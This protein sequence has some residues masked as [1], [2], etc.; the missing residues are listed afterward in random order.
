MPTAEPVVVLKNTFAPWKGPGRSLKFEE[1]TAGLSPRRLLRDGLPPAG[2]LR[3]HTHRLGFLRRPF[4]T[5]LLVRLLGRGLHAWGD[6][7]GR[8]EPITW[9]HLARL[10]GDWW[11]D[12]WAAGPYLRAKLREIADLAAT[13]A[14]AANRAEGRPYYLRTDLV[15]GLTSGGSIAHITGVFNRLD[16]FT[17]SP[18]LFSSDA[19]RGIRA[20]L[21]TVTVLPGARFRDDPELAFLHFTDTFAAKVVRLTADRPP[22]FLYQRYSTNNYAGVRLRR[23]W[24]VPLVLEFNG[25]EVWANQHW[26][27]GLK[28]LPLSAAVEKLNLQA[29]DVIVVVSDALRDSLVAEGVDGGKVLVNPNGVEPDHFSPDL[30]GGPVRRRLGLGDR[31]V[32]GFIGTFEVWHGVEVLVEAFA[33]LLRRRPD[34]GDRCRLL[35]V[36]DGPGFGRVKELAASL[37][38]GERC[39]FTGRVVQE[40]APAHLAAC[41]V[42]VSPTL[43]NKDGSR[44]FGSPTKLFEYMAMGK[45][46]VAS[47]LDQLGQVLRHGATAWLTPPG[48]AAAVRQ[49]LE[50]LIDAPELRH[51]LGAAARAEV[52]AK[53]TWGEHVR[54]ILA[55]LQER[56][57]GVRGLRGL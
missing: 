56:C 45:A 16:H 55:K 13:V 29:A 36:G 27:G 35:L 50:A 53:Y 19:I 33:E 3:L 12:R 52:L 15:F 26:R 51:R 17:P 31:T 22:P 47:D 57:P 49:G 9:G 41:D 18:I 11:R 38:V 24:G 14:P 42:L 23:R 46:V 34:L 28:Y 32:I 2:P 4:S 8:S 21:E 20:D 44:F 5:A 43:A 10:A 30:D 6:D 37:G 40:Q 54:R 1:L 39:V 7:A 48:D 25:S